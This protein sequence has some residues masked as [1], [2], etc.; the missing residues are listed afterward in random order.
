MTEETSVYRKKRSQI[1]SLPAVLNDKAFNEISGKKNKNV[2]VETAHD[3]F[4]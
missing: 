4:F 1:F 3:P 2:L